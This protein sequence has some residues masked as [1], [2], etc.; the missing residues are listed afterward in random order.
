MVGSSS[1]LFWHQSRHRLAI[2]SS[3]EVVVVARGGRG[4]LVEGVSG[5]LKQQAGRVGTVVW[6]GMILDATAGGEE[7]EKAAG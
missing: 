3:R 4:G 6:V 5:N 7:G 2:S 1:S